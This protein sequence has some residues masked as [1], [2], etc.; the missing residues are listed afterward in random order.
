MGDIAATERTLKPALNVEN[1]DATETWW[2]L[3]G[4][5]GV[6]AMVV[7]IGA[8]VYACKHF[9]NDFD[10]TCLWMVSFWTVLLLVETVAVAAFGGALLM[11][12]ALATD[13]QSICTT[14]EV[15]HFLRDN[16]ACTAALKMSR[17][18]PGC[19]G[20]S[21][22]E[23]SLLGTD[24]TC[25]THDLL[26]CS[27]MPRLHSRSVWLMFGGL[28]ASALI[29]WQLLV[30][31]CAAQSA[32]KPEQDL[33]RGFSR[34]LVIEQRGG[35]PDE[36]ENGDYPHAQRMFVADDAGELLIPG[37]QRNPQYARLPINAMQF[38]GPGMQFCLPQPA[39]PKHL[40]EQVMEA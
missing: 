16:A 19:Y 24:E 25:E 33:T 18:L 27:E 30:A 32:V 4:G 29:A 26:A 15:S 40:Y 5:L 28:L 34:D 14:G 23:N 17:K 21:D 2:Q 38:C 3:C 37:A 9:E 6:T 11:I 35:D 39:Q 12:A 22:C 1:W 8:F 20:Q 31:F 36:A 10:G 13:A 7:Y